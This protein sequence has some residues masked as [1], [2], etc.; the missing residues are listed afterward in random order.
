MHSS[1]LG[2]CRP[3]LQ[4]RPQPAAPAAADPRRGLADDLSG[5][6]ALPPDARAT[7]ALLAL[8][9]KEHPQ[10]TGGCLP[11]MQRCD[12][13]HEPFCC[14]NLQCINEVCKPL[15]PNP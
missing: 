10:L 9:Q 7:L 13:Y 5:A 1:Q 14:G 11:L 8:V 2:P 6:A 4:A 3:L 15:K 12:E